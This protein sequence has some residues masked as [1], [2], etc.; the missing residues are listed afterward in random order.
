MR[1]TSTMGYGSTLRSL[2]RRAGFTSLKQ[3]AEAMGF[4]N[5][6]SVQYYEADDARRGNKLLPVH[7]LIKVE[8]VLVGLGNP[9]IERH[10]VLRLA[11][12]SGVDPNDPQGDS[13]HGLSP[14]GPRMISI[15]ELDVAGAPG[16][17]AKLGDYG[18]ISNW[19]ISS[20]ALPAAS[21]NHELFLIPIQGAYMEPTLSSSD[22]VFVDATENLAASPGLYCVNEGAGLVVRNLKP[23]SQSEPRRFIVSTD[24]HPDEP[25]ELDIE[26]MTITGRVVAAWRRW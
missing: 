4:K 14:G 5:A 25:Y 15:H 7:F 23:I 17:R 11:L 9:P 8:K 1:K 6:S 18:K 16:G 12:G 22:R 10:E 3:F 13:D 24:S 20:D 19:S 2:R 21:W 26:Q